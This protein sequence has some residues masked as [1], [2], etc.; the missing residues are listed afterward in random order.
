MKKYFKYFF[1]LVLTL[2][3]FS[4]SFAQD[5]IK[6]PEAN[7]VN[8]GG[9]N[10]I[11]VEDTN[12]RYKEEVSPAKKA[13]G[14]L[15]GDYSSTELSCPYSFERDLKLGDKGEDVRLLQKILNA[16]R[17]TLVALTGPGSLSHETTVLGSATVDAIKRF[18]E[19]FKDDYI[20][21][22][23]G[24]FGPRTRTVMNAICN[25]T[26]LNNGNS[27][28]SGEAYN[29]VPSIQK[30][31]TP[32]GEV[33]EIP[34]DKIPPQVN[35]VA[36]VN[37]INS[38]DSFKTI[39]NFS[40]PVKELTPDAIIVDG[41]TV[42]EIRKLS[43]LSY[44][45]LITP[46]EST[47][48]VNVQIEADKVA[49]LAGNLNE[50]GSNEVNVKVIL[51]QVNTDISGL[52]DITD[53]IL[54]GSPVC[55]YDQS[56]QLMLSDETGKIVNTDGCPISD[57]SLPIATYDSTNSCYQGNGKLPN[58]IPET[59]RCS[60]KFATYDSSRNCYNR[61]GMLPIGVSESSRC[62][63]IAQQQNQANQ[64]MQNYYCSSGYQQQFQAQQQ[65]SQYYYSNMYG[66]NA[67][68]MQNPCTNSSMLSNNMLGNLLGGLLGKAMGGGGGLDKLFGGDDKAG[69]SPS[70]RTPSYDPPPARTEVPETPKP[71]PSVT[72]PGVPEAPGKLEAG[73]EAC[74][75]GSPENPEKCDPVLKKIAESDKAKY[76]DYEITN[77][78]LEFTRCKTF[79]PSDGK[80]FSPEKDDLIP[81]LKFK[82]KSGK[83]VESIPSKADPDKFKDGAYAGKAPPTDKISCLLGPMRYSKTVVCI[84]K[85]SKIYKK[86]FPVY[87]PSGKVGAAEKP[88]GKEC[89]EAPAPT[90]VS[91]PE[92]S[93]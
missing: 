9:E 67:P 86:S 92:I 39:V 20:F 45:V 31:A 21:V 64:N 42:K 47:K 57:P 58:G 12:E 84:D 49:D 60:K 38:V 68:A 2:P 14:D 32:Q 26:G 5:D 17:R 41:G 93:T 55:K 4:F 54:G 33:T 62:D 85:T 6:L 24:N 8:Y 50:E 25:G 22:V 52:G 69:K 74:L 44:A 1:L 72:V 59:E 81:I 11:F 91:K 46:D 75:M 23:N 37:T 36:N 83:I 51:T 82:D 79:R 87:I 61:N 16:D 77:G 29:N 35:L 34:N 76:G 28:K 70:G 48:E 15:A 10:N 40:E 3:F 66:L 71:A 19:I 18:Q 7:T 80:D 13:N 78:E 63:N 90:K 88:S 27:I 89:P 43:K 65:Q 53:Q 73:Y 30:D 56:G